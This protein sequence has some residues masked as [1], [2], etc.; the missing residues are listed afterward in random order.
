MNS[1]RRQIGAVY[2]PLIMVVKYKTCWNDWYTDE[3]GH[4]FKPL[5]TVGSICE[6]SLI[7]SRMSLFN[8]ICSLPVLYFYLYI[9]LHSYLSTSLIGSQCT[10][11]KADFRPGV[12]WKFSERLWGLYA[13]WSKTYLLKWF[14]CTARK[15]HFGLRLVCSKF[16][17]AP[18]FNPNLCVFTFII[19]LLTACICCLNRSV[20]FGHISIKNLTMC[21]I[22]FSCHMWIW[23]TLDRANN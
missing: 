15:V 23:N 11:W 19:A 10:D 20:E 21:L 7:L 17:F 16:I 12:N 14:T 13:Q 1:F 8:N 4:I 3:A 18:L 22:M 2:T 9:D 5:F 6:E